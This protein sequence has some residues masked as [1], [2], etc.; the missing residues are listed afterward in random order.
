MHEGRCLGVC[1]V[2]YT[3]SEGPTAALAPGSCCPQPGLPGRPMAP[4]RKAP[5]NAQPMAGRVILVR[6]RVP[7]SVIHPCPPHPANRE[8]SGYFRDGF[9]AMSLPP[10]WLSFDQTPSKPFRAE[11]E[12][13]HALRWAVWTSQCLSNAECFGK[14]E[15]NVPCSIYST[16][17]GTTVPPPAVLGMSLAGG[18]HHGKSF[19]R[20]KTQEQDL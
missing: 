2:R 6:T 11:G 20:K 13:A 17:C 10:A 1:A 14:T 19:V 3:S 18:E 9:L 8:P 7:G 5:W 16:A 4:A 12:A 15:T